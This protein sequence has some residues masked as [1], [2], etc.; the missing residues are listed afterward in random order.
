[1][2][3]LRQLEYLVTVV[4]TGSFT[5]A[6]EQL[7]VTQPALSHQIRALEKAVGGPLLER[8][9]RTVR[10]TPM[11][12]AVLPHA[13]A[14]LAEAERL[15]TVARRTAGLEEGEL[16]VAAVYSV[17]L[18]ILPPVLRAWRRRH[19]GVRIRL[20]EYPHADRLQAAMSAGRA[21]VAIGPAPTGWEG[22]IRELGVEEFV[23]VLPADDPLADSP[24]GTVDPARL[25]DRDWVH[26][27]PDN[28]LADLLDRVGAR[29][30]F[31]PRAAVR[32]EQ[33]SAAP[34]LAAAGLG[35]ALVP[36]NIVPPHFDGAL[37]RPD[38]PIRRTLTA[39][40]RTRPDPLTV[41]F[42]D[43]LAEQAK[44]NPPAP[45]AALG[46]VGGE[47][48]GWRVVGGGRDGGAGVG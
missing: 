29:A 28:G 2:A 34:L 26:Y 20:R 37:L 47:G 22:P 40:T 5:R 8:L 36:A 44:V 9:P 24:G 23:I 48:E 21:D 1:M 33:T 32:A 11:G 12:R 38:P 16:E 46:P 13:R 31:Q 7:H 41:A 39:Y 25:A 27:A 43:L 42:A 15:R 17:S 14:A 19:P 35:P 45:P 30:G 10:L 6:A 4:D 18:G 3:T